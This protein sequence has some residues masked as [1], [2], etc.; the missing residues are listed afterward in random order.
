M[1]VIERWFAIAPDGGSGALELLVL[2]ATL[3]VVA[4]ATRWARAR[5]APAR[6]RTALGARPRRLARW[7]E[8]WCR[9]AELRDAE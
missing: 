2:L 9:G 3:V 5:R 4:A 1:D 7:V 8:L 6:G